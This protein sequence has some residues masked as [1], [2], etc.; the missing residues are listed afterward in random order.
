MVSLDSICFHDA[1]RKPAVRALIEARVKKKE[2][3]PISLDGHDNVQHWIQPEA[4]APPEPEPL[5][6]VLSP[7]DPLMILRKRARQFFGYEHLFEAYVPKDK[8]VFGYFALPV[9]VDE[10]IVAVLDLKTDRDAQ[11]LRI[12]KWSWLPRSRSAALRAR[13][14]DELAR[15]ERFQLAD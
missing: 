8:R 12:Q 4:L 2:L 6:H 7:F 3:L 14:E 13:I 9:L 5:V 11:K 1:K 10:R 15:F